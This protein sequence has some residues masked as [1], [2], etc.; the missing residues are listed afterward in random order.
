MGTQTIYNDVTIAGS[1]SATGFVNAVS[2][3]LGTT[4]SIGGLN[5]S[6]LTITAAASGS[7]FNQIQ[8]TV[9]G[10]SAST[11]ISLYNN[12]GINYLDLGIA[13]TRYNGNL[14]GPTFN[15]VRAGDSYVY[16]TSGN[17]V[18][19]AAATTG[20]LTFFT[21]GT[22]S[23]NERM[24]ITNT[25]NIG[26]GTTVPGSKLTVV[27]DI[28][29]TGNL[30]G[31]YNINTSNLIISNLTV[32]NVITGTAAFA[33]NASGL[34]GGFYIPT[35]SGSSRTLWGVSEQFNNAPG[36]FVDYPLTDILVGNF[37]FLL[38]AMD[39]SN[40]IEI[41]LT[42][43]LTVYDF[44]DGSLNAYK[45]A[46]QANVTFDT[47]QNSNGYIGFTVNGAAAINITT[48]LGQAQPTGIPAGGWASIITTRETPT[49]NG[50]AYLRIRSHTQADTVRYIYTSWTAVHMSAYAG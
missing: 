18:Q 35:F 6:P 43:V 17:L 30:F 3:N 23:A 10:V 24:R 21:G 36:T 26:I 13:S 33:N 14:Y 47:Y 7:V 42:N 28:S 2:A 40:A 29:A 22:L 49:A 32:T 1:L 25:G 37:G 41:R 19:G 44:N 45:G 27:G 48:A 8:N 46:Y 20:N 15:V 31:D 50:T 5:V 34:D 4:S 39:W 9:A 12:D 11:D 38:G 16:A